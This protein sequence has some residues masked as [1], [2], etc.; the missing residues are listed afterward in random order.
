MKD[1][2]NYKYEKYNIWII[3]Y[4][5]LIVIKLSVPVGELN[6]KVNKYFIV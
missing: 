6:D 4:V 5:P 2:S 1:H 3:I